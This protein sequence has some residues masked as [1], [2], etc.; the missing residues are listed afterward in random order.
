MKNAS[1]E[2]RGGKPEQGS[3]SMSQ[4]AK[5]LA[6]A[7]AKMMQSKQGQPHFGEPH[8]NQ[9]LVT[10]GSRGLPVKPADLADLKALRLT[11][12]EWNRLP[13]ELKQQLLQAMKGNYPEEYRQLIRDYF[14]NLAKTGVKE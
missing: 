12:D 4:A 10:K 7:A 5:N 13:G 2:M 9:Q 3:R 14:S 11:S 1:Q 8:T 6:Q